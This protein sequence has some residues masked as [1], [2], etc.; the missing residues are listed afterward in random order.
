MEKYANKKEA[1]KQQL[2]VT[3]KDIHALLKEQCSK[4]PTASNFDY[5]TLIKDGL[6]DEEK[7][8]T[9]FIIGNL[10]KSDKSKNTKHS[11]YIGDMRKLR[12]YMMISL[13]CYA[14]NPSIVFFQTI[15]G[16]FSHAYGLNDKG[17]EILNA[18]GCSCSVDHIR[19]HGEHWA[20]KRCVLDELNKK[21]LWR[22]SLDNLNFKLKYSK[23]LKGDNGPKRALN[24]ITGQ[25]AHTAQEQELIIRNK[26]TSTE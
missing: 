26:D 4:F 8:N 19:R 7:I 13:L 24:L 11:N 25:V 15:I 2:E 10:T 14:I 5:R 6:L 18:F 21:P 20:S 23:D 3:T 12:I 9:H 17:F 22:V 16:L 1:N